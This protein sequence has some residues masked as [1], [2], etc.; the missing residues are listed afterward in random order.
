MTSRSKRLAHIRYDPAPS[1]FHGWV[2]S[3]SFPTGFNQGAVM[4]RLDFRIKLFAAALL[5]CV[6]GTNIMAAEHTLLPTPKTVHIG[7]FLSTLKPVLSI[8]SGDTVTLESIAS[9][10]PA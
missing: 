9:I 3:L 4:N 5:G 6:S 7:Y 8:D 1:V 2:H 10:V